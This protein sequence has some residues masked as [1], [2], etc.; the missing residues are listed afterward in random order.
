MEVAR[1]S[2]RG[3]ITLPLSVRKKLKL[4]TGDK[5]E[6]IE[7]EGQFY[8]RNSALLALDR[9]AKAFEGEAERAGFHNVDD[10][11]AYLR[12]VQ[13]AEAKN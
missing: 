13:H 3:Q 6:F 5:V 7:K 4:K 10:M 9:V 12:K 1:L 8:L 11:M 2:D